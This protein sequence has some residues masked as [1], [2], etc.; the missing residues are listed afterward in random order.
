MQDRPPELNRAPAHLW[1]IG[2]I[3]LL[4]NSFGCLDYT[5]TKLD[6]VAYMTSVGMGAEEIA[7]TQMLPGWLSAFWALGV[8]GSLAGSVLLLVRSRH[9]VAAFAVSLIGLAVSQVYQ[10]LDPTL[11]ASM[12][13]PG[14]VAMMLLI[15]GAL[16]FFIGYARAMAR[17]GVLR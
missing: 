9:A 5:M 2:V 6:P 16:L 8:W 14:M 7:Y 13:S 15:W 11:P 12:H 4:W 3:G 17:R 10:Y 1:A